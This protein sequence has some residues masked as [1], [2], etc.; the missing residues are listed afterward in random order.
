L[1]NSLNGQLTVKTAV[2]LHDSKGKAIT[3]TPRCA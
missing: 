1:A 3:Y 2:N